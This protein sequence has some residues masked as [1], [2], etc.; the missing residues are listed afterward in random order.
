MFSNAFCTPLSVLSKH[1]PTYW[2]KV[3]TEHQVLSKAAFKITL[4]SPYNQFPIH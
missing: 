4:F 2:N 1:I 3:C